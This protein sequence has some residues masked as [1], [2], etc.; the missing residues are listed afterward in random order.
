MVPS[1]SRTLQQEILLLKGF[2]DN[3]GLSHGKIPFILYG[4]AVSNVYIPLRPLPRL[5][6]HTPGRSCFDSSP[7]TVSE[8]LNYRRRMNATSYQMISCEIVREGDDPC[9]R[10]S[11]APCGRCFRGMVMPSRKTPTWGYA[12]GKR[13]RVILNAHCG[14]KP[15]RRSMAWK[16]KH[17]RLPR[18]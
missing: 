6:A 11:V 1:R 17:K 16:E 7:R 15:H 13:G 9:S 4:I 3:P 14:I 8:A 5:R 18:T 2:S 10:S 12:T